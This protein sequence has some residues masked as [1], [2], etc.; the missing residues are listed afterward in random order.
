M[1]VET[2]QILWHSEDDK[3][4]NAALTS[5]SFLPGP[6]H[7]LATSGNSNLI[8]LWKLTEAS[9]RTKV[10]F[11]MALTRHDAPINC[12]KFHVKILANFGASTW[13]RLARRGRL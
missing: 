11:L 4:I 12:V 13:P 8:H 3:G 9:G 6:D 10:D 5:V 7:I 2:P 1:K